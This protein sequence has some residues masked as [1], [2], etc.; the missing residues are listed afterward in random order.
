MEDYGNF[1]IGLGGDW[2]LEDLYI[3]PRTFEQVYFALYSLSEEL[4]D[5]ELEKVAQ[6][7][8]NLPWQGGYSAVS[9]YN[10]LKYAVPRRERPRIL[11][12]EYH[13]PGIME[14]ALFLGVA[15]AVARTVTT[16]AR[17]MNEA[18]NT[19]HNIVR[20]MQERKL[21]RIEVARREMELSREEMEFVRYALRGM[22]KLLDFSSVSQVNALTSNAYLSLKI[23]LS[24]YRRVRTLAQYQIKGKIKLP[25]GRDRD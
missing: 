7:Y 11:A 22:S 4:S 9:F 2:S 21:L 17:A 16:I 14:I 23:L 20:G 19:Y 1:R 18:N 13:S 8:K 3:V 6:A 15:V 10:Q 5:R 12:I 25:R 24:L